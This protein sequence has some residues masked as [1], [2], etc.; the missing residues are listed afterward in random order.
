MWLDRAWGVPI[1][2]HFQGS[3]SGHIGILRLVWTLR[4]H[5]RFISSITLSGNV[6]EFV[7]QKMFVLC[8]KYGTPGSVKSLVVDGISP[9]GHRDHLVWPANYF[10]GLENLELGRLSEYVGPT[11]DRLATMFCASP[12]LHTLRLRDMDVAA[13]CS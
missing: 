12:M 8:V 4:P 11:V 2:I 13:G 10:I 3:Y 1:Q 7:V 6:D 5:A 9:Y